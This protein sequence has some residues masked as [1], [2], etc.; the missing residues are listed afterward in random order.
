MPVRQTISLNLDHPA[1]AE[2]VQEAGVDA[3]RGERPL[4]RALRSD[5][6]AKREDLEA[7]IGQRGVSRSS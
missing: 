2:L 7:L 5:L 1:S 4:V 6:L 3:S